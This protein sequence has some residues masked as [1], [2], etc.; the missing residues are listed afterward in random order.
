MMHIAMHDALNAVMPL[1]RQFAYRGNDFF[2][3]PVAAAAQAA[4]DVVLSQYPG[5]QARLGTELANWLSE[6]PNGPLQNARNHARPAERGR[7]SCIA[8]GRWL[9]FSGHVHVFERTGAYQTTPPWNGFVFQ[10]GFR[11][12]EAFWPPRARPVPPGASTGARQPTICGGI[13]RS[14]GFRARRQCRSHTGSDALRHLV[15]GIRRGIGE[16]PG[17]ATRHRSGGLI[18]GELPA[19]SQL[20]NMSMFDAYVADLDSKYEYNH[21]RPYTAIREAASDGNP[22]RRRI[23]AGSRCGP[24]RHIRNMC[25]HI[26]RCAAPHLRF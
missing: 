14:E 1:Y 25:L 26:R 3:D 15:D 8:D 20:L 13:Q 22:P 4:H 7:H 11:F 6:I 9:G 17:E 18:S 5:Q 24:R 21:W 19:C 2:A 12:A 23:R 10:P 16:P